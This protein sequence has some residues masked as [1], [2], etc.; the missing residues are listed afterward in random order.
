[1]QP[2]DRVFSVSAYTDSLGV[3]RHFLN[4]VTLVE[5]DADGRAL[6]EMSDGSRHRLLRS[7]G[8][9][10]TEAEAKLVA[11]EKLDALA[12]PFHEQ[13]D[14][15]RQEAVALAAAEQVVTA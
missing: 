5:M 15:L 2:G 7:Q 4:E 10:A 1:M 9:A 12:R 8:L 6:V 13:A 3:P 11:A 14:K